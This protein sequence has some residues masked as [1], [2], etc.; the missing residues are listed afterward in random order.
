MTQ[1]FIKLNNKFFLLS[2]T[3]YL[4]LNPHTHTL[5]PTVQVEC[6]EF[7]FRLLRQTLHTTFRIFW[8]G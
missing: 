8:C 4:G 2:E 6:L 1:I 3:R 5:N 7:I